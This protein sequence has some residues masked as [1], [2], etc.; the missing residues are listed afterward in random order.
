MST[1]NQYR[2]IATSVPWG[3]E[4]IRAKY[5]QRSYPFQKSERKAS[6]EYLLQTITK[7]EISSFLKANNI[8]FTNQSKDLY[9]A[10]LTFLRAKEEHNLKATAGHHDAKYPNTEINYRYLGP[11]SKKSFNAPK[12]NASLVE[13]TNDREVEASYFGG[14]KNG[15]PNGFGI[16]MAKSGIITIA[17]FLKGIEKTSI[18]SLY[19]DGTIVFRSKASFLKADREAFEKESKHTGRIVFPES[20]YFK[21]ESFLVAP[22]GKAYSGSFDKAKSS[23]ESGKF[24]SPVREYTGSFYAS[25]RIREGQLDNS[26]EIKETGNFDEETGLLHGKGSKEFPN[27]V[28]INSGYWLKGL[29]FG[30]FKL[31][32]KKSLNLE[33]RIPE[34]WSAKDPL[35]VSI[36]FKNNYQFAGKVKV[37]N[38]ESV[39]TFYQDDYLAISTLHP[40]GSSIISRKD[41]DNKFKIYWG[42]EGKIL[43][44]K[45]LTG[46]N[47]ILIPL[48]EHIAKHSFDLKSPEDFNLLVNALKTK[49]AKPSSDIEILKDQF[50]WLSE[51]RPPNEN[52]LTY[53]KKLANLARREEEVR[54]A[55]LRI[56]KE[57]C[58]ANLVSSRTFANL[59]ASKFQVTHSGGVDLVN[60]TS[61]HAPSIYEARTLTIEIDHAED[62]KGILLVQKKYKKL[63]DAPF[64]Y[65]IITNPKKKG[66][67]REIY[68]TR[69][70][71]NGKM[72]GKSTCISYKH[73]GSELK[74]QSILEGSLVK[75]NFKGDDCISYRADLSNK[76]IY[77][78][79]HEDSVPIEVEE[80]GDNGSYFKGKISKFLK[81]DEKFEGLF[82]NPDSSSFDR[83]TLVNGH[84]N[85]SILRYMPFAG[86]KSYII[87]KGQCS[88]DE[89]E[90]C[91]ISGTQIRLQGDENIKSNFRNGQIDTN[92]KITHESTL[93]K[94][95][96]LVSRPDKKI[97]QKIRAYLSAASSKLTE[98]EI[99]LLINAID[100]NNLFW[101]TGKAS[102]ELKNGS[103]FEGLFKDGYLNGDKI[104]FGFKDR[105]GELQT[106]SAK[107]RK[108]NLIKLYSSSSNNSI[109]EIKEA[110]GDPIGYDPFSIRLILEEAEKE[111][112][113]QTSFFKPA[114][115]IF[116]RIPFLRDFLNRERSD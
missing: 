77:I 23:R 62:K 79:K 93:L 18:I 38:T 86:G 11:L 59:E 41:N 25:N 76:P 65:I 104:K 72:F 70:D 47:E 105:N 42:E 8:D 51:L 10:L 85:G 28:K 84:L 97:S 22:D 68:K 108:G 94:Y 116:N 5:A 9:K 61:S 34:G 106:A 14:F 98:L 56:Y 20:E 40:L 29:A 1:L 87:G 2:N 92:L 91:H 95:Q 32:Y 96:G 69:V 115:S 48:P 33:S 80:Y 46:N 55:A 16:K 114:S 67:I 63:D 26:F 102:L 64:V 103:K 39:Q 100:T 109:E 83:K 31:T 44:I 75:S 37:S 111:A 36:N 110:I 82:V 35:T 71:K 4:S 107:F 89:D 49:K 57:A 101:G 45:E 88:K 81:S 7:L 90:C 99:A 60:F 27:G 21:G 50:P 12:N 113:A 3:P 73:E 13:Y 15:V 74:V 19:P 112:K 6:R 43:S 58:S 30:N 78:G 24:I 53:N 17:K 52:I 54:S 66:E